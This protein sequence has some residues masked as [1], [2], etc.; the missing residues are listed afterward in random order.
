[1]RT[2]PRSPA[3]VPLS[4]PAQR[5]ARAPAPSLRSLASASVT[6]AGVLHAED[7]DALVLLERGVDDL[8]EEQRVVADV[9]RLSHGAVDVG[10]GLVENRRARAGRV[11]GKP[12]QGA[13]DQVH[14]D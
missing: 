1:S 13:R 11:D 5:A 10:D 14:L 9:D 12:V 2:P 7:L 8:T 6:H 3:A 4:S